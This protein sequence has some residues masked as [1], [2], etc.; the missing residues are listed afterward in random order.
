MDKTGFATIE[1]VSGTSMNYQNKELVDMLA[2]EYALGTLKGR[3][4]KRF[5]S[6][7]NQ[8]ETVRASVEDWEQRVNKLAVAVEP[9]APPPQLWQALEQ[10]L[11]PAAAKTRWYEKLSFW[12]TLTLGSTAMA[13][14]FAFMLLLVPQQEQGY[15]M[16]IQDQTQQPVWAVSTTEDM[17]RFYVRNTRPMDMPPGQGCLLWVQ[18]QGSEQYYPLGLLPDDGSDATLDVD[19]KLRSMLLNGRLLVTLED[20]SNTAPAAPSG[21]TEFS[22]RLVPIAKI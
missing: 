13:G 17:E 6:L 8:D 12:R 3:A 16:L 9:V 4:R 2:A 10:R 5:E 19:Q 7:L 21:T 11:F 1:E 22:G 14:V 20:K 18:P 15:V